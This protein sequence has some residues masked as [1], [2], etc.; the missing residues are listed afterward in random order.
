MEAPGE[1]VGGNRNQS[2]RRWEGSKVDRSQWK[3]KGYLSQA[4]LNGIIIMPAPPSP[5]FGMG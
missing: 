1:Q 5:Q 3:R 2:R 4:I